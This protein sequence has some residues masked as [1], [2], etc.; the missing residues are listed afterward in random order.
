[1]FDS[2]EIQESVQAN[3]MRTVVQFNKDNAEEIF[4]NNLVKVCVRLCM[5]TRTRV[6]AR[7]CAN[8]CERQVDGEQDWW[9]KGREIDRVVKCPLKG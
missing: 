6:S 1:M 7:V 9:C 2:Q 5:R 8:I 4:S 3:S